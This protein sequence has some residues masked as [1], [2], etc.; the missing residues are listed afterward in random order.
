MPTKIITDKCIHNIITMYIYI[1]TIKLENVIIFL[2]VDQI[3]NLLR[4]KFLRE[5]FVSITVY[6]IIRQLRTTSFV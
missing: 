6:I 2:Q 1:I 4:N 3:C 5:N